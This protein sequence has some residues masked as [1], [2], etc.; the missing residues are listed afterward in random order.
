VGERENILALAQAAKQNKKGVKVHLHVDTGMNRLGCRIEEALALAKEIENTPYL[1]LEGVFTHFAASENP[2]EDFFTKGQINRF[3]EMLDELSKNGISP[4]YTHA[5]NSAGAAR[6]SL[7]MCNMVRIGLS[8]YGLSPSKAAKE[9]LELRP[10]LTL[11]S[12]IVGINK[13]KSGDSVSYG[14]N[15]RIEKENARIAVIPIGYFDG[16][17]RSY[18]G[19]GFLMIRGKKAPIVGN[20]CMDFMMADITHIPEAAINE[21]VLIFGEDEFGNSY[22]AEEIALLGNTIVYEL[23]ACLGPRIQRVFIHEETEKSC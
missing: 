10:A 12:R 2:E 6:F 7:P 9:A 8:L 3:N 13:C 18:S 16:I 11:T 4:P 19:K 5:A 14:R 20:I 17:H 15:Y 23:I 22:P 1:K 21:P